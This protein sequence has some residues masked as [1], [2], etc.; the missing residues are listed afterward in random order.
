MKL[1]VAAIA[2][3]HELPARSWLTGLF[4]KKQ[5]SDTERKGLLL[6]KP[7][8]GEKDVGHI[9]CACFSVGINTLIEA[10]S[11]QQLT[12][13]EEIG[14]LLKAGTGCGS[15]VPELKAVLAESYQ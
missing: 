6:G 1:L 14:K 5:L 8:A 9:V 3:D 12:S 4:A 7:P 15:C 13:V 2:P 11:S 10:V